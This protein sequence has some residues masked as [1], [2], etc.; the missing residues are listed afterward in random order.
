MTTL[1]PQQTAEAPRHPAHLRVEGVDVHFGGVHALDG[2]TF[3]A[4]PG[5][6]VGM[7]KVEPSLWGRPDGSGGV[8]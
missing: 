8:T 5:E 7:D 6:I 3:E 2:T 4:Q 1:A